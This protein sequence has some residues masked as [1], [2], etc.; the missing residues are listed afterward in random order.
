MRE[1]FFEKE[2]KIEMKERLHVTKLH[3]SFKVENKENMDKENKVEIKTDVINIH[4]NS[5]AEKMNSLQNKPQ[6]QKSVVVP[7]DKHIDE[8]A[9]IAY[10]SSDFSSE[11][12]K[13]PDLVAN[14]VSITVLKNRLAIMEDKYNKVEGRP[15]KEL[16]DRLMKIR[17]NLKCLEKSM[18]EGVITIEAYIGK[19]NLQLNH[20]RKLIQYFKDNGDEEKAKLCMER[21]KL[22]L[23]E[24]K[25]LN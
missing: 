7:E 11:E 4:G 20:D 15:P 9:K 23:H 18:G 13:D 22:I 2:Y 12:L 21:V 1:P 10:T 16:R 6:K 25:E 14:L 24:L 17:V 19:L 8:S 3:P 5:N